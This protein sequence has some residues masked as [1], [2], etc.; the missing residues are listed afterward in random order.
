M[1]V[2][3]AVFKYIESGHE[4]SPS[5]AVKNFVVN[6]TLKYVRTKP[7]HSF[8]KETL[9]TQKINLILESNAIHLHQV[10]DS[11]ID[12]KKK[13]V[14]YKRVTRRLLIRKFGLSP[15]TARKL[16]ARSKMQVVNEKTHGDQYLRLK[17]VEFLELLGRVA[18]HG[19]TMQQEQKEFEFYLSKVIDQVL[20]PLGLHRVKPEHNMNLDDDD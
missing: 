7:L 20:G 6:E 18:H 10:Y 17:F 4:K 2:R 8:R 13:A 14:T 5:I 16:Y 12:V 11:L 3:C 9:W 15:E 19:M 1:L